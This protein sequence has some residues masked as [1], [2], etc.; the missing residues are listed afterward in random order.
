MH[1]PG[2]RS[3]DISEWHFHTETPRVDAEFAIH[4]QSHMCTSQRDAGWNVER[5]CREPDIPAAGNGQPVDIRRLPGRAPSTMVKIN[6]S[7]PHNPVVT[8]GDGR[9]TYPASVTA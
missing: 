8:I 6:K 1:P 7:I 2:K 9:P 3:M 5:V 4:P